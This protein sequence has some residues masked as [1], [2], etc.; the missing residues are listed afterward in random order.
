MNV[1]CII[2]GLVL[3]GLGACQSFRP[4]DT[5]KALETLDELDEE[6]EE[7]DATPAQKESMKAKT[8]PVKK[9]VESQGKEIGALQAENKRLE[10]YEDIFWQAVIG[11]SGL[12]LGA[13]LFWF[14]KK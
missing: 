10:W 8:A 3:V 5:E 13:G 7:S 12:A 1:R 11:L 9:I 6:I 14:L 4:R 2:F